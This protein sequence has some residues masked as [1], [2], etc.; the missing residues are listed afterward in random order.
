[1][2]N[3]TTKLIKYKAQIQYGLHELIK[4][5]QDDSVTEIEI[6]KESGH[7][8]ILK[9]EMDYRC[10][11][12]NYKHFSIINMI[13]EELMY[14]NLMKSI[15]DYG[16]VSDDRTGVGTKSL[17][18]KHLEFSL[19]DNTIPLLTTKKVFWKGVMEELLWFLKGETN[20]KS[21]QEKGVNIWKGNGSREF[22][23]KLGFTDRDEGELGP[24][25]GYQWRNWGKDQIKTIVDSLKN[26][27]YS[28]RHILSAWNVS[29]I[30]QMVLPPCHVMCQFYVRD[31]LLSCQ[32]YQRSADMFLGVPFNIASYSLLTHM[33]AHVTDLTAYRLYITFGDCHV[34]QNHFEAVENQ[35]K[36]QNSLKP[37]PKIKLNDEIKDIDDFTSESIEL[38]DYISHGTIKAPMA[39]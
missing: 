23:D 3:Q 34:Y 11:T 39:V 9:N 15:M 2:T 4:D 31:G 25:Y 16:I 13:P 14:L 26:N 30:D 27:P 36:L 6:S 24:V 12:N 1:M 33:L 5:I 10:I 7:F 20:S 19:Y 38:L 32:L 21:L 37:F 35:L 18:G 17:F 28:R 29:D 22:L 8:Y